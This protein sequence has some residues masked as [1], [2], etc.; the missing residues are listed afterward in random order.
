MKGV[1]VVVSLTGL[2]LTVAPSFFVLGG[3]ITWGTHASLMLV[4]MLLW[5]ASAPF[6]FKG[7]KGQD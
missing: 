5:F 1:L 3:S 6:W 4:G 7:D 2:V